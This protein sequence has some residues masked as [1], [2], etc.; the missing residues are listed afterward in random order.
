MSSQS[1]VPIL[2]STI[3]KNIKIEKA[4][5]LLIDSESSFHY[6]TRVITKKLEYIGASS[7]RSLFFYSQGKMLLQ[8]SYQSMGEIFD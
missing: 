7:N 8:N 1:K 2:L 4:L 5:T 3:S 6:F